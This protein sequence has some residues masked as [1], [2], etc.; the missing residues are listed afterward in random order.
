MR[1]AIIN[2]YSADARSDF[3]MAGITQAEDLFIPLFRR[4]LPEATCDV[5]FPADDTYQPFDL[6]KYSGFVWT[7]S[8]GTIYLDT[9]GN[10]RQLELMQAMLATDR[11][12]WGSCWGLQ[13]AALAAGGQVAGNRIGRREWLAARRVR[14]TAAGSSHQMFAGKTN[15]FDSFVMHLDEVV[16]LPPGGSVLATND[17]SEIQ[18]A[19][20]RVGP[21]HFWGTQYHP[22]FDAPNM[23]RLIVSRRMNL[24]R[25]GL[26]DTAEHFDWV[27]ATLEKASTLAQTETSSGAMA[28]LELQDLC[29]SI[30]IRANLLQAN[31]RETELRNWVSRVLKPSVAVR[32]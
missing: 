25:E 4:L 21:G 20:I 27:A 29:R 7:G 16:R 2:G 18:A 22:E 19:E 11:P 32:S 1:L 12:I 6:S 24:C 10:A 28:S 26:S 31:F 13:V 15:E 5:F 9:P 23:A 17:H 14:I 3:R 30:D 8:S